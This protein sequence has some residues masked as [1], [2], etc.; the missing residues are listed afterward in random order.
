M[1]KFTKAIIAFFLGLFGVAAASCELPFGQQTQEPTQEPTVEVPTQEEISQELKNAR[2]YIKSI[3]QASEGKVTSNLD[4]AAKVPV[5]GVNYTVD[6]SV[7]VTS[8]K[9]DAV[10]VE[11]IEADGVTKWVVSVQ[12]NSEITEEVVFVLTATITSPE[13]ESTTVSFNHNIPAFEAN[14]IAQMIEEGDKEKIY[15][16][17]GVITTVNKD[18]GKTAFLFVCSGEEHTSKSI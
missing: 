17:E 13:G 9:A 2:N 18:E 11:K 6:W 16:L 3:Y 10:S 14:T 4:R 1:K 5:S 12:Y 8:G 7:S 15:F